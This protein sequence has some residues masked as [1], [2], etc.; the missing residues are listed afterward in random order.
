MTDILICIKLL[1]KVGNWEVL[2]V[3]RVEPSSPRIISFGLILHSLNYRAEEFRA[4]IAETVNA[5]SLKVQPG[6][7][8]DPADHLL[9]VI[10]TTT[11]LEEHADIS[12]IDLAL[13]D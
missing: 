9:L 11:G 1:L 8:I 2:R 7:L 6:L 10:N 13:L 4:L 5:D 12:I 3:V